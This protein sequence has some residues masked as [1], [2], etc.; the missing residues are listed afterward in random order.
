MASFSAINT[1]KSISNAQAATQLAF[2][3]SVGYLA[4]IPKALFEDILPLIPKHYGCSIDKLG[5][6]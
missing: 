1:K 6:G 4:N 3:P 2:D 5:L